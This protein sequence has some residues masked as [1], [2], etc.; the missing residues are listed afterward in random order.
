MLSSHTGE[1]TSWSIQLEKFY[2]NASSVHNHHH[3][4]IWGWKNTNVQKWSLPQGFRKKKKKYSEIVYVHFK[5]FE[6]KKW[7]VWYVWVFP[8]CV[9]SAL[10]LSLIFC[11]TL[12]FITCSISFI[13]SCLSPFNITFFLFVFLF[14]SNFCLSPDFLWDSPLVFTSQVVLEWISYIHLWVSFNDQNMFQILHKYKMCFI[15]SYFYPTI[16]QL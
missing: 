15:L 11:V 2:I 13:S 3:G 7:L 5:M 4:F 1:G 9:P 8:L 14:H 16:K 12:L 10:S 6:G